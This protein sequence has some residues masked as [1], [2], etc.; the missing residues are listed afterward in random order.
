MS[1]PKIW[2]GRYLYLLLLPPRPRRRPRSPN[3]QRSHPSLP[4]RS[5]RR[6]SLKKA[7]RKTW[8]PLKAKV[9]VASEHYESYKPEINFPNPACGG[10]WHNSD[11]SPTRSSQSSQVLWP[12]IFRILSLPLVCPISRVCSRRAYAVSQP[13]VPCEVF[14]VLKPGPGPLFPVSTSISAPCMCNVFVPRRHILQPPSPNDMFPHPPSSIRTLPLLRSY[15]YVHLTISPLVRLYQVFIIQAF[16][17]HNYSRKR[18]FNVQVH[19]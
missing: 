16:T 14:S 1:P 8:G 3:D 2:H 15:V 19:H 12:L 11:F 10:V 13:L 17:S 4:F 18:G 6:K 7:R 5:S 9:A